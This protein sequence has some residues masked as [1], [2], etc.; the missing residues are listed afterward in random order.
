MKSQD[1]RLFLDPWSILSRLSRVKV[2]FSLHSLLQNLVV[3]EIMLK[4]A[5]KHGGIRDKINKKNILNYGSN[6]IE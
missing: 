4:F 2:N 3:S 6:C 5:A 1:F